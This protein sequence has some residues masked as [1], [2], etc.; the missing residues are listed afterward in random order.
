[1][2]QLP[3]PRFAGSVTYLCEHDAQGAFGLTIN[4]PLDISTAELLGQAGIECHA[5]GL[6]DEPV[7][8]GG[9][10]EPQRGFVLHLGEGRWQYSHALT[11]GI[12]LTTSRDVLEA[13]AQGKGPKQRLLLLGYAGWGPGQLEQEMRDNSW[14]S[15]PSDPFL[16]FETPWSNRWAEA[17]RRL[18]IDPRN[19]TEYGGHA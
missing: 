8:L 14:L 6:E 13:I 16:M 4:R 12:M 18:G 5:E 3:D 11:D 17:T 15:T 9:P 1:M 19:L 7:L 10:V 2:P